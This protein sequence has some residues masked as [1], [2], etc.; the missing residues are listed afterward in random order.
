MNR[1][2]DPNPEA[3]EI[4][5]VKRLNRQSVKARFYRMEEITCI[6]R[7]LI[8]LLDFVVDGNESEDSKSLKDLISAIY[9]YFDFINSS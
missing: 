5:A 9:A 7:R 3:S 6:L 4:S 2:F 8:K 1:C